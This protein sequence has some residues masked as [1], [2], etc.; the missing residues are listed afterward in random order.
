MNYFIFKQFSRIIHESFGI[1]YGIKKKLVLK[2]RIDTRIKELGLESYSTYLELLNDNKPEL[3]K[4]ADKITTNTTYFFREPEHFEFLRRKVF[5]QIMKEKWST[6]RIWSAPCSTGQELYS[7]A[8]EAAL[9]KEKNK[10]FNFKVYGSDLSESALSTA[11]RG[12]YILDDISKIKIK[13]RN[14]FF[15][16]VEEQFKVGYKIRENTVFYKLNL[17]EDDLSTQTK[18]DVIFCRNMLM[19]FK[20]SEQEIIINKLC[21]RLVT[22]GYFIISRNES[23]FGLNTP[24]KSVEHSVFI[25]E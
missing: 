22:G 8:I 6:I 10:G 25:K 15:E 7:I 9:F 16:Q 21:E 2:N 3:Q 4:L 23:I 24:L 5:T 17:L 20:K 14:S 19:Y 11:R 1:H 13:V 18:F 12:I